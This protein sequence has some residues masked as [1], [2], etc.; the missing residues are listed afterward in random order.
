MASEHGGS[1][2]AN[3]PQVPEATIPVECW[4]IFV[5]AQQELSCFSKHGHCLA[6]CVESIGSVIDR[7]RHLTLGHSLL[8]L[9]VTVHED[10]LDRSWSQGRSSSRR[11]NT[12]S[13][14][15]SSLSHF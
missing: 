4:K 10:Y 14:D 1:A 7:N 8:T 5:L 9:N 2:F 6:V 3:I 11:C 13:C 15:H 12:C